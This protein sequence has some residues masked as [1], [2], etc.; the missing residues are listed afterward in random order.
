[1]PIAVQAF[2][3]SKFL[4]CLTRK[5]FIRAGALLF[6][7]ALAAKLDAVINLGLKKPLSAIEE[8]PEID[9][10]AWR[11]ERL[12]GFTLHGRRSPLFSAS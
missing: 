11:R 2:I 4:A 6:S 8:A 10:T 12:I 5:R 9:F 7:A 1:L 3:A